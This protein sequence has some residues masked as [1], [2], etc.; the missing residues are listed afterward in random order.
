MQY[1]KSGLF[2]TTVLAVKPVGEIILYQTR[3][4][5]ALVKVFFLHKG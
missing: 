4:H 2:Y 5:D 1:D 3:Q